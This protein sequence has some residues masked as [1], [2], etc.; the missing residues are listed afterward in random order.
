MVAVSD[1]DG[2][3][4]EWPDEPAIIV[5]G[6][7]TCPCGGPVLIPYHPDESMKGQSRMQDEALPALPEGWAEGYDDPIHIV[8]GDSCSRQWVATREDAEELLTGATPYQ[9]GERI[10][11]P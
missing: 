2:Y 3:V 10:L 5:T 11:D 9:V 8:C 6:P 1:F 7:G 4:S